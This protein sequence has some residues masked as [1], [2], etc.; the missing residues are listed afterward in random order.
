MP[1]SPLSNYPEGV[2]E[3]E[4]QFTMK[5]HKLTRAQVLERMR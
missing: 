5:K 2:T 3:E 1:N 4:M